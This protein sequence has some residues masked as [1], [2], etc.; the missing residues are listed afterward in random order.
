MSLKQDL[1][2]AG[3]NL[4]DMARETHFEGENY[5]NL[6]EVLRKEERGMEIKSAS[7]VARLEKLRAY[8]VGVN[9]GT[10]GV[11]R[12][13]E[14]EQEFDEHGKLIEVGNP[15]WIRRMSV[16]PVPRGLIFMRDPVRIKGKL[17]GPGSVINLSQAHGQLEAG[18]Y[19]FMR[20]F[21]HPDAPDVPIEI[22]LYGGPNYLRA[23]N[24]KDGY[25]KWFAKHRTVKPECFSRPRPKVSAP[26]QNEQYKGD[27]GEDDEY[28][29]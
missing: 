13:E 19:M 16:K 9:D 4:S 29:V 26:A 5:P 10:V 14:Q 21:A 7:Q 17:C 1:L 20:A 18:T 6:Y 15:D 24:D 28:G 3:V 23:A 25:P 8:L 12:A 27:D 2:D 22:D 11:V